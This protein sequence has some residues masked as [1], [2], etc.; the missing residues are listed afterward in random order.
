MARG[1]V[2]LFR[3]RLLLLGHR[4]E[5]GDLTLGRY[6]QIGFVD[7]DIDILGK[8][9]NQ[10]IGL[11]EAGATLEVEADR[12]VGAPIEQEVEDPADVEILFDILG[13][14]LQVGSHRFEQG[15]ALIGATAKHF[16]EALAHVLPLRRECRALLSPPRDTSRQEGRE[17]YRADPRQL[18]A[19]ASFARDDG[20]RR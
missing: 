10:A 15:P 16:I 12:I 13:A 1:L 3:Q 11:A 20:P 17:C 6:F 14:R 4:G 5:S 7:A 19:F 8:A 18:I 9:I 2:D